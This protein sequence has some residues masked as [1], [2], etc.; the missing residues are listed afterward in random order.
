MKINHLLYYLSVYLLYRWCFTHFVTL[1]NIIMILMMVWVIIFV[2]FS[3]NMLLEKGIIYLFQVC[4]A[5]YIILRI[6][7][8]FGTSQFIHYREV[9][10]FL[11]VYFIIGNDDIIR[12]VLSKEAFLF[13]EGPLHCTC[14]YKYIRPW[15]VT[16]YRFMISMV[17]TPSPYKTMAP[18]HVCQKRPTISYT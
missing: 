7:E 17:S 13:S 11:D 10:L 6:K 1:N 14:M 3:F 16:S 9:V 5:I 8:T 4:V 18:P 2:D 12:T 15:L